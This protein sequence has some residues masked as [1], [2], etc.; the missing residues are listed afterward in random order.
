MLKNIT[1]SAE[2]QVIARA[3]EEAKRRGTTLNEEFRRWLADF[4]ELTRR[5]DEYT[6][7]MG[8]LTYAS[9]GAGSA[10]P[11]RDTR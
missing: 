10:R 3:R 9:P 6:E 4:A 8:H 2:E 1:L 11:D 7:L 5:G